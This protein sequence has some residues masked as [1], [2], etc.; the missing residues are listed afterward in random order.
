[1]GR[2]KSDFLTQR[3][4]I[5]MD[6]LWQRG[7]QSAK[8][9]QEQLNKNKDEAEKYAITTIQTMCKILLDKGY[10]SFEKKGRSFIYSAKLSKNEARRIAL[11][12]M[13]KQFF[14]GSSL[15]LAQHLLD[16]D[17]INLD[18]LTAIK[19]ELNNSKVKK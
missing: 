4:R 6:E 2:T 9:I 16:E 8:D 15:S 17:Q 13:I 18:D 19:D 10:A 1:M 5:I 12:S 3:E 14:G 11:K 7:P